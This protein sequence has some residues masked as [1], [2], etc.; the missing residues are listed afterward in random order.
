MIKIKM[1]DSYLHKGL[2]SRLV[3]TLRNKGVKDE[4][5]LNAIGKVLRHEFMDSGFVGFAYKDQAFPIGLGQTISQP[6]TVAI[7]T[8]LLDVKKHEKVLEVGTGSGYQAAVL[9]QLGVKVF[10]I[11]RHRELFLKSKALLHDLKYN[12]NCFYGDGYKGVPA[13]SPYDKILITAGASTVPDELLKQL[14]IGGR[15]VIP[16]G[17]ITGQEMIVINKISEDKYEKTEHGS[18]SFVPM[19]KGKK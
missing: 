3:E 6:Y 18:F 5:V 1:T 4:K 15:M 10:T 2:R 13:F 11:E 12:P 8:E 9:M 17:G 19:L 7:Q 16:I 14:K